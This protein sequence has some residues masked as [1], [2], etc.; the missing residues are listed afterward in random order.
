MGLGGND[1]GSGDLE[2]VVSVF[3]VAGVFGGKGA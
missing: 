3:Q 1:H 2:E